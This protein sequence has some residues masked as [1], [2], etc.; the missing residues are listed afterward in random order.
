MKPSLLVR[1][2]PQTG[3][4]LARQTRRRP[5]RP[6]WRALA[7]V[8]ALSLV[9]SGSLLT[10][11][12]AA[13]T[14][15][16][17]RIIRPLTAPSATAYVYNNKP[18]SHTYVPEVHYRFNSSGQ[19]V[20]IN[21]TSTGNYLVEFFGLG[22]EASGGTVDVTAEGE[23][24][25]YCSVTSW[26]PSGANLKV[27]VNCH[28][29]GGA[30]LDTFFM[31]AFTSGGSTTGTTDYVWANQDSASSYTPS[32]ARQFNSSGGT[33]TVERL[34]SGEYVVILPGPVVTGGTV[35]VTAYGSG[36]ASCQ[37]VDWLSDSPGQQA[38]VD[39]FNSAGVLTNHEFTLTFTAS[40]DLLGDGGASGYL[41]GN[42]PTS[43]SYTPDSIYQYDWVGTTATAS[44]F[45]AGEYTTS[46]PSASLGDAGDEQATAY[47]STDAHC[48]VDGPAGASGGSQ[49]ADVFCY[50]NSGNL[51]DTDYTE[52]WMVK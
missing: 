50:D 29:I 20:T 2:G 27:S 44:N 47:G 24:P 31:A 12:A 15:T 17:L 11:G 4:R 33:N 52:Q 36:A 8:S 37:V 22:A 6:S 7:G 1:S 39:C 14:G 3:F 34:S 30:P 25:A 35:K 49:T 43:S 28:A 46:F 42:D 32:L 23:I 26:G 16:S 18:S 48:S 13:A 41:W 19:R 9:T 10:A 51:V 5:A 45:G 21:R 40:D 38:E